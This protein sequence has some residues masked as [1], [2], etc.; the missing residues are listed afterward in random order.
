MNIFVECRGLLKEKIEG[1]GEIL[2]K[3]EIHRIINDS[4]AVY[5]LH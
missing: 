2:I 1:E 5:I 3:S 4:D